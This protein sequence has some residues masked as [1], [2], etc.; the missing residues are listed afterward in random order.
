VRRALA[1]PVAGDDLDIVA[2][3]VEQ[4]RPKELLKM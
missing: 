1:A 4:Q 2:R 3:I